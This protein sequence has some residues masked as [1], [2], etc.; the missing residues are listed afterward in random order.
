MIVRLGVTY[1]RWGKKECSRAGELVYTGN[2][3]KMSIQK[4]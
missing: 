1:V 4:L 2:R 3:I